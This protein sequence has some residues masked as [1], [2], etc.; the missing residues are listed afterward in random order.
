[1]MMAG[2][3]IQLCC[4]GCQNTERPTG[5]TRAE[6]RVDKSGVFDLGACELRIMPNLTN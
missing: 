1:M 2:A 4:R 5:N 6:K 3:M